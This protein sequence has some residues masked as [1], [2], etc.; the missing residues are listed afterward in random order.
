MRDAASAVAAD[1]LVSAAVFTF[2]GCGRTGA[3]AVVPAA[4][5][6]AAFAAAFPAVSPLSR[7]FRLCRRRL[8]CRDYLPLLPGRIRRLLLLLRLWFCSLPQNPRR[9][10]RRTPYREVP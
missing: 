4:A 1:R 3:A 8:F 7:Y 6:A 10:Y 9:R 2:V 5:A